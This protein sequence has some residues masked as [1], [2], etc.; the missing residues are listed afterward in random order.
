MRLPYLDER[1]KVRVRVQGY[2]VW[3]ADAPSTNLKDQVFD[4]PSLEV[5]PSI[6]FSEEDL[7]QIRYLGGVEGL[8][9]YVAFAIDADGDD[10]ICVGDYRQDYDRTEL[11]AAFFSKGDI[12]QQNV[13]IYIKEITDPTGCENF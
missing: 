4:F 12:G 7:L 11:E 13:S 1:S 9:Y 8:M 10:R 5:R 6:A 2:D 3:V